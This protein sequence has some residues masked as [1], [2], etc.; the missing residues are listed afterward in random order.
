M[1]K[2][3]NISIMK[4][5]K[6]LINKSCLENEKDDNCNGETFMPNYA[7]ILFLI[8]HV[9]QLEHYTYIRSTICYKLLENRNNKLSPNLCDVFGNEL[10]GHMI[11]NS[12]NNVSG[13]LESLRELNAETRKIK[14]SAD[15]N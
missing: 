4:K 2:V 10:L 13:R 15:L 12:C 9:E 3:E 8:N 14:I 6:K 11:N 5:E 1:T 7:L